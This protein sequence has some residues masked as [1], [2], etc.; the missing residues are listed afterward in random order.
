M[1]AL[2]VL[3]LTSFASAQEGAKK[4]E[5]DGTVFRKPFTLSLVIDK[6]K[7]YEEKF[8]KMPYVHKND[9]YLFSGDEFGIDLEFDGQAVKS[10]KYQPD[11]S[12]AAVTIKLTQDIKDGEHSMMMAVIKSQTTKKLYIDALKTIPG[13]KGIR[14]TTILPLEP[15]LSGYESWP[16]PIV[17]LV[18]RNIR[19]TPESPDQKKATKKP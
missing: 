2:I 15:G 4:T 16:H 8:E 7:K 10:V 9:V 1:T 14:R 12:K 3:I 17:Q 13:Q 6:T 11:L 5:E 19:T 18:L